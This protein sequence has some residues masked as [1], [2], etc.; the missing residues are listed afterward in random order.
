MQ[1]ILIKPVSSACNL[2]C[3]YC[4]YSDI[5]NN[6]ETPNYGKMNI[7]SLEIIVQKYLSHATR[8]CSF[9]FQGGEPTLIGLNYYKKLIEFQKKYNTKN[10]QINNSIQTNGILINE[11]WAD[12]LVKNNF[13][14]GLSL[15]G[16]KDINDQMRISQADEGTYEQIINTISLFNKYNITYNILTVISKYTAKNI[17][18]I[19]KFYK[20]NNLVYQQYI[21]CLD[22]IN[23]ERGKCDYSL[24]P[25]IYEKFLKRLFDLWYNDIKANNF[26]YN[27]Y[28]ENLVGLLKGYSPESC[29]MSGVCTCQ[30]VIE[31]DGSIYPCDF[32][33]MDEYKIGNILTDSIFDIENNETTKRF[34]LESQE[35]NKKCLNC[36]WNKL[37]RG[38]CRRDRDY[39]ET[40]LRL[41]YYCNSYTRFFDYSIDRLI[42]LSQIY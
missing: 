25:Q 9:A 13:L 2:K 4:F 1:N 33:V 18:S 35:T 20:E 11:E 28:F 31:A 24:T 17:N 26:I 22:P 34:I 36:K 39:R 19:Y 37:C 29:G 42:E 15:D 32:Y 21:P 8:S 3:K 30:N 10:I 7:N 23:E 41:N 38:G 5:S 12:F 27:R 14:V 6:R 16:T 40:I